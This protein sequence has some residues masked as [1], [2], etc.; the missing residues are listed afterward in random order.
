[1]MTFLSAEHADAI[2]QKAAASD[3]FG[4]KDSAIIELQR[5]ITWCI[6]ML[7]SNPCDRS[8]HAIS[9]VKS[10]PLSGDI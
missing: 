6:I 1:M 10:L 4:E 9:F 5:I 3:N 8:C 2:A 7:G